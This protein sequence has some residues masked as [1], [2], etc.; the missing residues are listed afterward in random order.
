MS[1][2]HLLASPSLLGPSSH[3]LNSFFALGWIRNEI[4][5]AEG[6]EPDYIDGIRITGKSSFQLKLKRSQLSLESS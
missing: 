4:L 5:E 2:K 1:Q 6:V 3:T